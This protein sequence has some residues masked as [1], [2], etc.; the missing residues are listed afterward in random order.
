MALQTCFGHQ[1]YNQTITPTL[2]KNQNPSTLRQ[3]NIGGPTT[4]REALFDLRQS[5]VP[6]EETILANLPEKVLLWTLAINTLALC[7]MARCLKINV[8]F[9][10]FSSLR[11]TL[12]HLLLVDGKAPS[13]HTMS[14]NGL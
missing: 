2:L 11:N 1:K 6:P 3:Q 5:S 13:L 9:E 12:K 4:G 10:C 14:N 7:E 8:S